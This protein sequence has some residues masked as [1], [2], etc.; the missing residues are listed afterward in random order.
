MHGVVYT[1]HTGTFP[2]RST[3][4]MQYILLLYHY[5]VNA[6][7]L[8][9]LRNR[10]DAEMLKAYDDLYDYLDS[11]GLSPYLKILDNGS[12]TAVK[13]LLLKCNTKFQLV[14]PHN[15]CVNAAECAIRTF[16]NHFIDGLSIM[17][18]NFPIRKW[19]Q[20]IEQAQLTMNLL[21][22]SPLNRRLSAKA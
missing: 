8:K 17:D 3:S 12:S 14:K 9:T 2:H 13:I 7:L 4:G 15:H 11:R 21:C 18:P 19:D 6:T 20:L 1:G 22:T 10:Y 16:K 5:D